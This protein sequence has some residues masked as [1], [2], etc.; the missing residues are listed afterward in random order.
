MY[1][2][3]ILGVVAGLLASGPFAAVVGF[4]LGFFIDRKVASKKKQDPWQRAKVEQ[5][6]F[7]AIFPLLGRLAKADGHISQEEI[8]STEALMTR[9]GLDATG[10]KEAI[11]LFKRGAEPDYD[12]LA[13]VD[14][15]MATCGKFNN[16]RQ[17]F[18]VYL[19]TLAYADN[20]LHEEE[21]KLLYQVADRVGYSRYAFNHLLGMIQAQT[22]FFHGRKQ[23]SGFDN[24][25]QRK[26]SAIRSELELAYEALGVSADISD[27][28]L[29]KAY[30]KLMSEYHPDKLTGRGVPDDMV[31]L[32][33][34]RSQEVQ[35]A[36]D[37]IKKHRK[38]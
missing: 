13:T 1:V 17:I 37:M 29:K 11:V 15:F 7:R 31:K 6:F 2:G 14:S 27:R 4:F 38:G 20:V 33:T 18:L 26:H 30:R 10:R 22:H 36:Y 19:I 24:N 25:F 32:A 16:L 12:A 28:E 21:E 9:M 23:Q 35:A 3:R 34:E 5:A 8:D